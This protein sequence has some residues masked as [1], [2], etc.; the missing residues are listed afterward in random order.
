MIGIGWAEKIWNERQGICPSCN[1]MI[2][3]KDL[4]CHH[5][6]YELS[7]KESAKINEIV[8][9]QFKRSAILG[10]SFMIFFM[11]IVGSFFSI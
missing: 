10:F 8:N 7:K 3:V 11:F 2:G 6:G 1:R 5:C 4:V 9:N